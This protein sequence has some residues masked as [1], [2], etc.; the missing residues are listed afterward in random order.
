VTVDLRTGVKFGRYQLSLYATNLFD[1][2]G[3]QRATTN[4]AQG[5]ATIL[6]QRTFGAVF[7]A[8]F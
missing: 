2:Y 6:M 3:F 7:S 8:E 1:E 5:T 4:T